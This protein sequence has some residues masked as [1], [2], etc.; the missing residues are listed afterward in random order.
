MC[1]GRSRLVPRSL[2]R[3]RCMVNEQRIPMMKKMS[4]ATIRVVAF[5]HIVHKRGAE[6]AHDLRDTLPDAFRTRISAASFHTFLVVSTCSQR[7]RPT[8]RTNGI[9]GTLE[10]C[11]LFFV[12]P[13]LRMRQNSNRPPSPYPCTPSCTQWYGVPCR[14]QEFHGVSTMVQQSSRR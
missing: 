13:Q 8:P 10:S 2:E 9:R 5:S 12:H 3:E 1:A 4:W 7:F 11:N 14:A 6:T